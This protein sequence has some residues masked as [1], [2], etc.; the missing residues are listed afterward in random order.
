MYID[1]IA[2]ICLT[3]FGS[4]QLLLEDR[5]DEEVFA[6]ALLPILLGLHHS[7]L[8]LGSI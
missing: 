1:L 6:A 5:F 3:A 2:Y 4:A 7:Q 8:E